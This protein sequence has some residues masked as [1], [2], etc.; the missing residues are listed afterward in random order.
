MK[1]RASLRLGKGSATELHSSPATF[2]LGS[3]S[4]LW[5]LG[6]TIKAPLN[7][8]GSAQGD[9]LIQSLVSSQ[10]PAARMQLC[11]RKTGSSH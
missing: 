1:P 9:S 10:D 11:P 5:D 8:P 3:F 7:P 6:Y 4:S 2:L